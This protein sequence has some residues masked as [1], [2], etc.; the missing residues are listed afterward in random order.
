[1]NVGEDTTLGDCDVTEKLV[2]FL[3]VSDGEL[4][5]TGDDTGLLVVASSIAGQLEDFSSKVLKDSGEVDWSTSTDTLSV[6]AL[7]EET[8]DTTDGECETGL[9]RSAVAKDVSMRR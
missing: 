9:G 2:Q 3:V 5:M 1:V 7:A 8:V 6:V 4:K